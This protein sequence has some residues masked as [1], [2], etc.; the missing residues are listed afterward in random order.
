MW[1]YDK[2]QNVYK[3]S[4]GG[5]PHLDAA[6]GKQLTAK[7]VIIVFMRETQLF[8]KKAH[9]LY[10]T[11]GGGKSM[12]FLDGKVVEGEWLRPDIESRTKFFDSE[13]EEVAFNRGLIWLEVLPL[14]QTVAIK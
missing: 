12:V 10:E 9:L 4:Q 8:D 3:R 14:E 7:N 11:V 5:Q 2:E 1:E 13:G 6:T